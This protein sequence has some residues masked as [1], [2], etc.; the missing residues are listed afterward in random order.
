[1]VLIY[2]LYT[3]PTIIYTFIL[4]VAI[5]IIP[6]LSQLHHLTV[7]NLSLNP[8]DR[9]PDTIYN[10]SSLTELYLNDTNLTYIVANIGK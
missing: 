5:T 2:I 8:L 10:S 3:Y 7:L 4:F 9:I 1:M 6:E